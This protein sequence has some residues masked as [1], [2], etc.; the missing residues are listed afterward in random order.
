MT[1]ALQYS[2]KSERLIL[3][4]LFFCLKTALA[5]QGF[6]CFHTNFKIVCS[7]SV[8]IAIGNLTGI[9]LIL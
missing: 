8:K 1:V 2:L 5:I 9:T 6:L 7:S 4:A 3:P